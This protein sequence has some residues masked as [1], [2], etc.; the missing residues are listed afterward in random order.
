MGGRLD[1]GR[2]A[3]LCGGRPG[4]R[5]AREKDLKCEVRVEREALV[6][7]DPERCTEVLVN[8]V[9]NAVKYSPPG[10]R[11]TVRVGVPGPHEKRPVAIWVGDSGAGFTAEDRGRLFG[12][13]QRLSAQPAAGE[14]SSGLGLFIARRMADLRDAGLTLE[15]ADGEPACFRLD[16]RVAEAVNETTG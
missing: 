7:V 10:G 5:A 11:V 2:V 6:Q 3:G 12:W 4:A 9:S 14:P 13:F 1:R 8:L 15:R 16:L